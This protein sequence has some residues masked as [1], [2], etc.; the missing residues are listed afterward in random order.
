MK[1]KIVR[2]VCKRCGHFWVPKQ[3]DVRICPK[4]KSAS[5]DKKK[6]GV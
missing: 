1:I 6:G 5:F 3:E 2:L 4:C